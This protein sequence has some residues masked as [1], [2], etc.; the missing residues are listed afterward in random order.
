MATLINIDQLREFFPFVI[1]SDVNDSHLNF[2]L[3]SASARLKSWVGST[4][5]DA[6]VAEGETEIRKQTLQNAEGH[7]TL[8]FALLGLNTNMRNFGLV[9]SE[10]VEG[11]TVNQYF[12]PG[13]VAN[14]SN[15]YLEMA[16]EI[17]EPYLLSD[18]TPTAAFEQVDGE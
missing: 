5:Y 9:K 6:A 16:R 7:L 18:G 4:T 10:Q 13:E 3:A 1:H 15:Q 12:T 2:S 11:N 17:A 14:F 8:H